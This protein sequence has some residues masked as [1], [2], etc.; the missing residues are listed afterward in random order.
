MNF[1][2]VGLN[3]KTAPVDVREQLSLRGDTLQAELRKLVTS[4]NGLQAVFL[5]TCNRVE[6]YALMPTVD[7]T[8]L[9]V[10]FKDHHGTKSD[11]EEH[12][13]SFSGVD[14]IRH[15]CSVASG[16]DSMVL[17]EPQIFGQ[18]KDAV[19]VA[20]ACGAAGKEIEHL[21]GRVFGV[22]KKV[23]T[24]TKI[25]EFPLSV[26]YAAV[27]KA[28]GLFPSLGN[29]TAM[30]IGAGEMSEL[31]LR[32]LVT[33]GI[34]SILIT[35]RTFQKAVEL[36]EKFGGTPIMIHEIAAYLPDTDIIISSINTQDYILSNETIAA[37]RKNRP[38]TPL[39]IIDISVPR[40]IDP[41][42]AKY[43]NVYLYNIDDLQ[44]IASSNAEV[45]K[46]EA[47]KA[48]AII[49]EKLPDIH[50]FL[51]ERNFQPV[52]LALQAEAEKSRQQ[53]V[54]EIEGSLAMSIEQ[55]K[56]LDTI[57]KALVGRI[58][59]QSELKIQEFVGNIR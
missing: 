37:L 32:N 31:T 22:V 4:R 57:T 11:I 48:S 17:G 16:L 53:A 58:V 43:E 46:R 49:E 15:V 59:R 23:R 50:N 21:F 55:K 3:H 20:L 29:T 9:K 40:S 41:M 27:K 52:I 1:I 51:H 12:L 45:R 34:K 30:I 47:E 5:S 38:A 18:I 28:Q 24:K 8:A 39:F 14:A 7:L 33:A 2:V 26:S 10:F 44:A 36:S 54:E 6:I 42:V 13:Y 56:V 19:Q 25:G 35:N